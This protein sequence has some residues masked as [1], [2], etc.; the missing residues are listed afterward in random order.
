M[1]EKI[2]KYELFFVMLWAFLVV[3][4]VFQI[5]SINPGHL[6]YATGGDAAKN[7]FTF[8]YHSLY[9]QDLWFE[10]MNYPYGEHVV[11]PDLQ[12]LLSLSFIAFR[13]KYSLNGND[14]LAFMHLTIAFSFVLA[15]IFHHLILRYYKIPFLLSLLLATCISIM[16]PQ[17]M[18]I[19]GHYA[20]A[21]PSVVAML[22][23]F[24]IKYHQ[25]NQRIKFAI[26]IFL[27]GTLMYLL[28]PYFLALCFIWVF[29]YSICYFLIHIKEN[30]FS[31][32]KHLLPIGFSAI[33]MFAAAKLFMAFTDPIK[34]RPQF[35]HGAMAYG[36]VGEQ[37]FTS[38]YSPFWQFVVQ[39]KGLD[40]VSS[41]GEGF[42]YL[43]ISCILVIIFSLIIALKRWF[44]KKPLSLETQPN[45]TFPKIWLIM[46]FCFLLLGMGVPF[47]WNMEWLLDYLSVFRQFRSLGRFIWLF[48]EVATVFGV[49]AL[50]QFYLHV[51]KSKVQLSYFVLMIPLII[52]CWESYGY[53]DHVRTSVIRGQE[54]YEKFYGKQAPDWNGF[55]RSKNRTVDDFQ[56]IIV[57]P[58]VHFGSEKWSL[59][60]GHADM[61]LYGFKASLSAKL[62]LVDVMMPRNSWSQTANQVRISGGRYALKP[63]FNLPSQKPFL[64]LFAPSDQIT[65]DEEELKSCAEFLGKFDDCD[66]YALSPQKVKDRDSLA[67]NEA[68]SIAN[69]MRGA[70][71]I[72]NLQEGL[73]YANHF[74]QNSNPNTIWDEGSLNQI[75]GKDSLV[76]MVEVISKNDS[77]KYE[78][79]SWVLLSKRDFRSP[80]LNLAMLDENGKEIFRKDA[81]AK[82]SFDN[83]GMWFRVNLFF[84]IPLNCRKLIW[85]I[86][87]DKNSYIALD[88]V[89]IRPVDATVI[90]KSKEGKLMVNNHLLLP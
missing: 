25:G 69:K 54:P 41:G 38:S 28:H 80:V 75:K 83:H 85:H 47:V 23:Y 61:M 12:P 4:F 27:L 79:S 51:K 58:F 73:F 19:S 57:F 88:E 36:S 89:L 72:V 3:A 66:V 17:I 5:F 21:Y 32:L 49:V 37:I 62:P 48:Y 45:V 29:L 84:T 33:A 16:S 8:L 74:S 35:P 55:L 44:R 77:R 64:I 90:Y 52:W 18:R 50:Y 65:P 30:F 78:I 76:A 87:N 53:I 24:S 22:F 2:R 63:I 31:I 11:F 14:A 7:Y 10:G 86:Y 34:D 71:T 46:S 1:I 67:K 70:D 13:E 68:I 20:L 43:G 81:V 56:A 60:D 82:E 6:V 59:R 42:G 9:G 39:Q 15:I 26:F 40:M